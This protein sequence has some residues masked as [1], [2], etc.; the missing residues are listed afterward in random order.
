MAP[1]LAS[2]ICACGICGLLYLDRDKTMRTSKALWLP[3]LWLWFIGSRPLSFWLG[4]SPPSGDN[5][6]L[7][8]SPVD[9]AAFGLL[10]AIGVVVLVQR[11][12]RTCDYLKANWPIMLYF[13]YCLIS[14]AWS[15][16]SDVAF[17]RWIKAIGD[18]VMILVVVTDD[19]P[20]A[21]LSSLISRVGFVLCPVSVLFIKYYGAL[22][23][24]YTP[25]GEPMNTGVTS[26][27]N[28]LGVIV[29]V[30]S[31]Y[32]LRRV[33]TLVRDR[34]QRA[35]RR[36]L[37]AQGTLLAFGIAL[38]QMADSDTSTACFILGAVFV[39]A[40]GFR[41]IKGR[42]SRIHL[43]CLTMFLLAGLTLL[44]GGESD[45]VHAMG[46]KPGLSGRTE[47]WAAL[48]SVDRN[49]VFGAGFESFWIGPGEQ[50]FQSLLKA[51]G[52]WHPEDLNEAHDGYLEVY[53][54]L[55][56]LGVGLISLIL[57]RG[58]KSAVAAFRRDSSL[59][60]LMLAYI[61]TS[62][63]YSITEAGFR[64]LDPIWF[65]LLLAMFSASAIQMGR[66]GTATKSPHWLKGN[67][68]VSV[69]A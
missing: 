10:L 32:T 19:H 14:V 42:P 61:V 4:M 16:H 41:A 15:Y 44:L 30:I 33:V 43:L 9:A 62:A 5:V 29:F 54:E 36:H 38:L 7:N 50:R 27:K 45:V 58:Y 53:L 37:L 28:M 11:R 21:A 47:I 35:R 31:L 2:L 69:P 51:E 3:I 17:K 60:G 6:Q 46:R 39:V 23:R 68:R 57:M 24:A 34:G 1:S 8:G 67:H 55:G 65:F 12:S 56:W 13:L 66:M 64:M 22:G 63:A 20:A 18:P 49:P 52:W 25:V 48:T 26:N 59:G 40:T